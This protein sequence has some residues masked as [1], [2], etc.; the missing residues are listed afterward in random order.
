M[1]ANAATSSLS[2]RKPAKASL[3][4]LTALLALAVGAQALVPALAAAETAEGTGSECIPITDVPPDY[5]GSVPICQAEET[6]PVTGT[7]PG[8]G[9]A[10]PPTSGLPSSPGRPTQTGDRPGEG[11]GSRSRG[12][13][14]TKVR[15][16]DKDP[17]SCAFL[18]VGYRLK[19]PLSVDD[20]GE[21][22]YFDFV[23]WERGDV[24]SPVPA[25]N[26]F[27]I[28]VYKHVLETD[29]KRLEDLQWSFPPTRDEI[30][31]KEQY[32]E[33]IDRDKENLAREAERLK[34][35]NG[36]WNLYGCARVPEWLT[37]K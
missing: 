25:P 3:A 1:Q 19:R 28:R 8:S 36:L 13:A 34:L 5:D 23:P 4:T 11:S 21:V 17:I 10:P 6:I 30:E 37:D 9:T 12:G 31:K 26:V 35:W 20:D 27:S 2:R 16:N 7:A 18:R 24:L 22:R 32:E 15:R 29:K 14:V 33:W